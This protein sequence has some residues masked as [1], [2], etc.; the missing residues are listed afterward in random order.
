MSLEAAIA[1]NTSAIRELIAAL[2]AGTATQKTAAPENPTRA[3]QPASHAD[4]PRTAEAAAAVAPTS[5]AR[6]SEAAPPAA[7]APTP[8][9]AADAGTAPDASA[10]A[11]PSFDEVRTAM[12]GLGKVKGR[13]AVAEM[14]AEF[15]VTRLPEIKPDQYGAMAQA[16][17]KAM[18]A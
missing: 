13:A 15:G 9:E 16:I 11:T 12:L 7:A 4:T 2:S 3:A 6:R 14:L 17:A 5:K 18:A 10:G 8:A 1:E